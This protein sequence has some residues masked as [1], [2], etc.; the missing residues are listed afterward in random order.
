MSLKTLI[1][2]DY[3][4]AYG[5]YNRLPAGVVRCRSRLIDTTVD[6]SASNP[7]GVGK[8]LTANSYK[9]MRMPKGCVPVKLIVEVIETT[10]NTLNVGDE[11]TPDNITSI[12]DVSSTGVQILDVAIPQVY[13][14]DDSITVN[15]SADENTAKLR[16]TVMFID[17][18][19]N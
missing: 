1:G 14:K 15:F 7:D 17:V 5:A 2:G 13:D 9:I 3:K 19:N 6:V 8:L 18:Y 16:I 10:I 4:G 11:T 12:L